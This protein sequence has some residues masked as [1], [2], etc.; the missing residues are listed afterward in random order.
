[1][2]LFNRYGNRYEERRRA[3]Q[4][5][6]LV[7]GFIVFAIILFGGLWM[8]AR[9]GPHDVSEEELAGRSALDDAALETRREEVAK[10][11]EQFEA[12]A[13][14]GEVSPEDLEILQLAIVRQRELVSRASSAGG[15][16]LERLHALEERYA[17]EAGAVLHAASRADEAAGASAAA[18][19][20]RE[21]AIAAYGRA[22]ARQEEINRLYARGEYRNVVR[23]RQLEIAKA[24][25]E[26]E[27]LAREAR[28][29][30]QEARLLMEERPGEAS[31]RL[32]RA[33]ALH[34]RL[35]R[36]F[37]SSRHADRASQREVEALL[38][39]VEAMSLFRQRESMRAEAATVLEGGDFEGA[40]ALI[41]RAQEVQRDLMARF[42][43]SS[44]ARP[45][46]LEELE[47]D[48]QSVLSVGLARAT[49]ARW[50]TLRGHLR[51]RE[52][53]A[54]RG[55]VGDLFRE[56]RIL[57][58][59]FQASRY[60]DE[61]GLLEARYLNLKR[62]DFALIQDAVYDRLHPIPGHPGREM[63][64]VEVP[65]LLYSLIMGSNP[66]SQQGDSL[67]VDSVDLPAAEEFCQR[68]GWIL[69]RSVRLPTRAEFEQALGEVTPV[70]V[71]ET[72]WASQNAER[73]T[74]PVGTLPANPAGFHDLLGNVAEW[75][76][77]RRPG[78]ERQVLTMGGSVRDPAL[79]LE[80]VPAAYVNLTE[81][82]RFI[83]FRVVVEMSET[84]DA[85]EGSSD[86]R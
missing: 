48:R 66:S 32:R 72:A 56:L 52:V 65:Q 4:E 27:P 63:L 60:L 80:R 86:G 44:H 35:Q 18:E 78:D 69:G 74:R 71:R 1:V 43:A 61:G 19:G 55:L 45:G 12:V 31:E 9:L 22:L 13:A 34:D 84:A 8:L 49:E 25:L 82:S 57:H 70:I 29:L 17:T 30:T 10:L 42:P 39:D 38:V 53:E 75:V 59:R 11:F 51:R 83:G 67:P 47:A 23:L 24:N 46:L 64:R 54:A 85:G 79:N 58:D 41:E 14:D 15:E 36:D 6:L 3:R 62:D 68:L 26:A 28:E 7:G 21:D 81:R 37:R 20:R 2:G 5:I 33:A 76:A 73:Q 77:E 16:D 50:E 40:A